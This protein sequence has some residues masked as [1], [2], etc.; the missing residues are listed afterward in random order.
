MLP[1]FKRLM[2]AGLHSKYCITDFPSVTYPTQASMI[3]GT[4]TGNYREELCH[5]V[6]SYSW[7]GRY[8]SPPIRRSYGGKGS[9]ELIQVYKLNSDLGNNCQ[10]FLEMV[11][12]GNCSSITQFISRGTDYIFPE[13]KTKLAMYYLLL[14]SSLRNIERG[15]KMMLRANTMVVEKVLD[16]FR[17]PSKYFGTNEAPIGVNMWFMSSDAVMH[18][19]GFDS[20]IYIMNLIHIDKVMGILIDGLK[21]LGYWDDTV[22]AVS[23]DHG[24]YKADS[25]GSIEGFYRRCGLSPYHP[26]KNEGGNVNIAEFGG[27]GMFYFKKPGISDNY[28]WYPP[29]LDDL[30]HYGPKNKNMIKEVLKLEGAKLLYYPDEQNSTEKGIVHLKRKLKDGKIISGRL[31]YRGKG[32]EIKS[33]YLLEDNPNIDIFGY[34][35]KEEAMRLIDGNYHTI[36]EW[37]AATFDL[38]FPIYPD[39]IPRHFKNPRSSDLIVSTDG[40]VVFNIDHGKM[41]H[42]HVYSHDIGLQKSASVPLII[43]GS[44]EVPKTEISFCKTTDIV[45]T[46]M[47]LLDKKPHKSVVGKSLI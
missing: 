26:K 40:S 41:K 39:L 44:P 11:G 2:D 24:N 7:M 14:T 33:K 31:E 5:G 8:Y 38:D 28:K 21:E 12:E 6:P 46:L 23:A 18:L 29:T 15:K 1:N 32:P 25:V 4:Y 10:T 3:T 20:E 43:G 37:T 19:F 9:D 42:D 30:K 13:R 27:V 35:G 16:N 45:P 47:K 22:I 34:D 36:D 17:N